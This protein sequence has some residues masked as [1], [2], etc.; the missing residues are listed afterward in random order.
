MRVCFSRSFSEVLCASLRSPRPHSSPSGHL[1]QKMRPGRASISAGGAGDDIGEGARRDG[2]RRCRED[3]G[4]RACCCRP[5]AKGLW[6]RW[7]KCGRGG[8]MSIL[9]SECPFLLRARQCSF[10]SGPASSL[11]RRLRPKCVA[12]Q[13]DE[14][15]RRRA[16]RRVRRELSDGRCRP[17]A[18]RMRSP[19]F[20]LTPPVPKTNSMPPAQVVRGD[21]W[22]T[23]SDTS[24]L[25]ILAVP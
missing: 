15:P 13:G 4:R 19:F 11:R 17:R 2:H 21:T 12:T 5:Q 25:D 20:P 6:N 16:R 23:T 1:H 22:R 8:D 18:R 24:P 14:R 3:S 7:S 10:S 9:R